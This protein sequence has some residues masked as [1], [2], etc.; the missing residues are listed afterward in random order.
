VDLAVGRFLD[1]LKRLN[2]RDNT[3]VIFSSDNGPETLNRYPTGKHS[4]G[5]TGILRGVKLHTHD[6]G[7]HVAGIMNW[8]S[9]IQP[10]QIVNETASSLDLLPTLCELAQVSVP[11]DR[12]LDGISLA[13][14]L[15]SGQMPERSRPLM[16][17]YYNSINAAHVAMRHGPWKVLAQLDRGQIPRYENLTPE[18]L[19]QVRDAELTDIEIYNVGTDPGE[20]LNLAGR[21]LLE[22]SQLVDL[23][24][25][26]YRALA[27]DS[28]PWEPANP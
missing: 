12:K 28:L 18:R 9:G 6:G 2:V 21:G 25:T 24:T 17:A 1:A 23:L 22:E 5:R 3:L 8:P 16:W 4:W 7:F 15:R 11:V 26:E 10:G 27:A 20:T 19:T 14:L 13:P